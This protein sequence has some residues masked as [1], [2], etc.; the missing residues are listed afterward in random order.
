VVAFV[1][2]RT[3]LRDPRRFLRHSRQAADDRGWK[4]WFMST[5][6]AEDG[7]T[8][9]RRAVAAG[10]SLVFAAG[11]D[12]TVRACAEALAGTGELTR[13]ETMARVALQHFTSAGNGWRR[14]E[15]ER[16]LGDLELQSERRNE[17]RVWWESALET[18]RTIGAQLEVVKLEERLG[19]RRD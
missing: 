5:S 1:V 18:A 10:A 11:G 12:G 8:L 7:G 16:L 9:T 3:L 17:A 14:V 19:L 13:A 15:C 2:N 4:P 6:A